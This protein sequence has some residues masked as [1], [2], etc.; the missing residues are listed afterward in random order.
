MADHRSARALAAAERLFKRKPDAD[1]EAF[2]KVCERADKETISKLSNREFNASYVLPFRRSAALKGK[3]T[4][5]RRKKK[6]T[7]RRARAGRRGMSAEQRVAQ[8]VRNRDAAL[9]AAAG[10][11]M[12]VYEIAAGVEA[13]AAEVVAT[14]TK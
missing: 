6:A 5:K 10:D 8:M 3:K 1:T 2:R 13:F 9:L 7:T 4:G 14:A 12:K 11:S